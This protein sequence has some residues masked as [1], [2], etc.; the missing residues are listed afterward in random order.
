M[1]NHE[2]EIH[3]RLLKMLSKKPN[4]TQRDMAKRM[5]ISLGK[6]NYCVTE[7]AAKGWIKIIRFKS[8]RNKT[9]YTYLLTPKG[10]EE[11][12]RMTLSFLKRKLSEYEEIKKQIRELHYDVEEKVLDDPDSELIVAVKS[13]I[14]DQAKH[15][16][17]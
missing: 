16:S 1:H 5:G 14:W 15:N 6:M 11:K 9:P 3:Y 17:M 7:L 10:L 12:A 8:A 13:I 4:V 2:Q